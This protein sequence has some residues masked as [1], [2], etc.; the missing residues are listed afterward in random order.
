MGAFLPGPSAISATTIALGAAVLQPLSEYTAPAA[1]TASAKPITDRPELASALGLSGFRHSDWHQNATGG[2]PCSPKSLPCMHYLKLLPVLTI[3][4]NLQLGLHGSGMSSSLAAV[5]EA[6]LLAG[7]AD[8]G[9]RF[10]ES[11]SLAGQVAATTH[12]AA[13]CSLLFCM[14]APV[15]HCTS[16]PC[17]FPSPPHC[18]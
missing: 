12:A 6:K 18:T 8:F 13:L 14:S 1:L 17:V 5:V 2:M 15:H 11:A 16:V 10:K 4:S 9:S 3:S 7:S